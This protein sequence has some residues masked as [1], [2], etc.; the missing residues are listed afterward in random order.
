MA[1]SVEELLGSALKA[2]VRLVRYIYPTSWREAQWGIAIVRITELM[3][4]ELPD[5]L[6]WSENITV[7]GTLPVMVP[8]EE[9]IFRGILVNDDKYG[10]QYNAKSLRGDYNFANKEDQL[11][12]LSFAIG[13]GQAQKICDGCE[14]PI[15]LLRDKDMK[16]LMKIKGI[17]E[18]S[19]R[20]AIDKFVDSEEYADAVIAFSDYH[21]SDKAIKKIVNAFGSAEAAVEAIE[22]NPYILIE[23]VRGYGWNKA[24]RW[25][26]Q[27]GIKGNDP[28]RA[29][30]YA[31]YYLDQR[32][33][34]NGDSWVVIDDLLSAVQ[35]MCAPMS[36]ELVVSTIKSLIRTQETPDEPLYYEPDTR[37]VSLV[38]NYEI[39]QGVAE[40][41]HRLMNG[42]PYVQFTRTDA[43]RFIK[44]AEDDLGFD[45][46]E[47]QKQAIYTMI[48]NPVS[49]LTGRAGVG[50][51]FS[52]SAVYKIF[53]SKDLSIATCALSG[54]ASSK[55]TEITHRPGQTIHKLL[56][57]KGKNEF[58]YDENHQLSLDV[59]IIDE[60]T[61]IGADIFLSLL[62]AIK[63]GTRV[64]MLGDMHQLEPIG[65]GNVFADIIKSGK[66]PVT[67][68]TKIHRQ[69]AAS[70]IITES[71]KVSNGEQLFDSGFC[72]EEIRGERKDFKLDV[73]HDSALVYQNIINEFNALRE[74]GVNAD[75]I[76]ILVPLK[77]RG[78]VCCRTLNNHL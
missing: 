73:V 43:D 52:T 16:A 42:H 27:A 35:G 47:E 15:K 45:Y 39:E 24:D 61:L 41:L 2:K 5:E 60:C 6:A 18:K 54:R 32:G 50:K 9:Y 19:A 63:T 4:G 70:G 37:R 29:R 58:M 77:D 31:C 67:T 62:K 74:Q 1:K 40:N 20:R 44:E 3:E 30:A 75:D 78:N 71:L 36:D 56:G 51:S 17:G 10:P 7:K 53:E 65:L 26:N 66:I 48:E 69:A 25:A 57:A 13:E 59:I 14:D 23:K 22:K 11:K 8:K 76:Q 55:L 33:E 38:D 46:T 68:L 49:V 28:R 64:I 21:L 34:A 72:G 12:F